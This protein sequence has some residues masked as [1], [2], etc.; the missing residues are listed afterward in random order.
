M[1]GS[2]NNTAVTAVSAVD[3]T[4]AFIAKRESVLP[5]FLQSTADGARIRI[6]CS[7]DEFVTGDVKVVGTGRGVEDDSTTMRINQLLAIFKRFVV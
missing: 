4:P 7:M 3:I 1:L 6:G 2:I 5:S